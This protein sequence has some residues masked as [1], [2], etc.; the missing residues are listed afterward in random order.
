MA[1]FKARAVGLVTVLAFAIGI[2]S[3]SVWQ[4][5]QHTAQAA[6]DDSTY[7][8]K[9]GDSLIFIARE[10]GITVEELAAAN[11]LAVNAPLL[12]QQVLIIPSA[13]T[14]PADAPAADS[15]NRVSQAA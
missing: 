3:L 10:L 2:A 6:Q 9:R 15:L 1:R 8:V 11:G 13:D 7:V 12:R 14:S 5:R 4:A